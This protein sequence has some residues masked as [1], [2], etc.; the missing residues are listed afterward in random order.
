MFGVILPG[1]PCLINMITVSPNKFAFSFPAAPAFS[2]IV[3]FILPGNSLPLGTAAAVYLELPGDPQFMFLGAIGNEKQ[4][5]IFRVSLPGMPGADGEG[6]VD[7]MTDTAPALAGDM[8]LGI[9]V[10][11]AEN[12]QAQLVQAAISA[13]NLPSTALVKRPPPARVLAQRIIKNEFNFLSGFAGNVG[14]QEVVPLKSFQDWW[15]KFQ[16]RIENDPSF[17]E[18]DDAI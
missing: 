16:R 7:A 14:G 12:I 8:N 13:S 2:H 18:R 10:E 5:A 15:I 11:P 4:S 1:R 3:V 9:S 17:L 6:D